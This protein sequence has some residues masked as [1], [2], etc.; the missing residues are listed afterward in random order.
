M[1]F[2]AGRKLWQKS[3]GGMGQASSYRPEALRLTRQASTVELERED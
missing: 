2:R 3:E 1:K